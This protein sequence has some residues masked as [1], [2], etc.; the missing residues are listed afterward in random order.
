MQESDPAAREAMLEEEATA[1][2]KA[3]G[4]FRRGSGIRSPRSEREARAKTRDW[5]EILERTA[6]ADGGCDGWEELR[7]IAPEL[8]LSPRETQILGLARVEERSLR[9]MARGLGL[10]LHHVRVYL[11]RALEKCARVADDPPVSARALF[12]EEVRRKRA[13]IYH[14][15]V[16][17]RRNAPRSVRAERSV[18]SD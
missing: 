12:W 5:D 2:L 13:A 8:R 4:A 11:A 15:P 9:E 10:S 1:L 14:P 6:T 3:A 18:E 7:A 16:H 17:S